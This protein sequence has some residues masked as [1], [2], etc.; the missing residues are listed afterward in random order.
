MKDPIQDTMRKTLSYWYVDGL[1]E[2]STGVLLVLVGFFYVVLGLVGSGAT[3][4]PLS[5]F[6]LPALILAGG[7][8][9]RW[10]V[11]KLKERLTYPRTGYVACLS[12]RVD[13]KLWS[14]FFGLTAAF[15]LVFLVV[16]FK[17]NWLVNAAPAAMAATL[18]TFI[19][20][21]YGLRRFYLLAFYTLLLGLPM[22][23]LPLEDKFVLAV[24]FFGCGLGWVVSGGLTLRGYLHNTQPPVGEY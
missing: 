8:L 10:T 12:N 19:G 20:W 18:I 14:I 2:L 16:Y 13:R 15:V 1:M 11:S 4:E 6:G 5:G 21:S 24:F 23:L 9:A 22:A 17:L 3:A 7:L